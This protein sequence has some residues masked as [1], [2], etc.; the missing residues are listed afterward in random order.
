MFSFVVKRLGFLKDI[1]LMAIFYDSLLKLWYFVTK[2]KVLD[3][4]DELEETVLAFKDT[5]ISL[6]KY[7]G[8]QFNYLAKE[9]AHLH[10]NGLLDI[11]FSLKLKREFME[12]GRIMNH[13]VFK[14]TGWIS[15]YINSKED[16]CYAKDLL[17][18][19]YEREV[20]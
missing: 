18:I 16:L 4:I 13:H 17:R 14:E 6:H 12:K 20:S 11:L 10:S 15:F 7:G 9:F 5:S 19:A 1:P 3:W 2:P 8:S